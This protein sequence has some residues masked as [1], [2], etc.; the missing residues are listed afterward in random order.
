MGGADMSKSRKKKREKRGS[1]NHQIHQRMQQLEVIGESRYQAKLEYKEMF[2][3]KHQNNNT[4]GVHTF[5]TYEG[6]K[7]VSKQFTE[8]LK[9]NE[10]GVRNIEDI[11]REHI[12][13]YVQYRANEGYS[14]DTYSRDL[15]ALNK[16]FMSNVSESTKKITKKECGVANKKF[17][18]I[19]NNRELKAHHKKINLDNYKNEQLVGKAT[20][21]RRASYTKITPQAFNK[22]ITGQI[23]SVTVKEKGGKVR[24]STVLKEHRAEL[25]KFIDSLDKDKPI[26]DK[27]SNRFPAHRFRQQYARRLYDEYIEEHGLSKKGFKGFDN[28]SILNVSKNLGHNRDYVVKNYI[29]VQDYLDKK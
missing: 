26:F 27:L 16:L 3:G 15:A 25:T 24:T 23:I 9:A 14:A 28:A 4:V 22:D 18:N 17:E 10:K 21:I 5:K 20:G 1:L 19:T 12:I 13:E 29:C 8:W 2:G 6:Y 11:T 7:Q